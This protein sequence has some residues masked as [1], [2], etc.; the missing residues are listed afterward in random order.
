MRAGNYAQRLAVAT[1]IVETATT[2]G[3]SIAI[4]P[5]PRGPS[6]STWAPHAVSLE[7]QRDCQSSFKTAVEDN[8]RTIALLGAKAEGSA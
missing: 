2:E 5:S 1:F 3:V 4:Q 6:V 7:R 8:L